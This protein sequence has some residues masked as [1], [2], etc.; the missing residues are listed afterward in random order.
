M[1]ASVNYLAVL[2]AAVASMLIGSIWYGPLFGK[3]FMAAMGMDK[4]TPEQQAAMKKKMWMSYVGQF[5][6]STVMFYVLAGII[7]G[8]A[9]VGWAKGAMSGLI[10]WLGFVLPVKVGDVAW[11]GNKTLFWLE[12][13]NMLLTLLAAGAILGTWI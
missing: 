7:V 9:Q 1:W 12:S 5:I 4:W 6:A 8:F 3:K 2:A 13:L 11:G 10:M